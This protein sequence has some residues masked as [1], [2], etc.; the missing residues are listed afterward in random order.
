[1]SVPLT[2]G[3]IPYEKTVAMVMG[4]NSKSAFDGRASLVADIL[5][6]L[7]ELRISGMKVMMSEATGGY[8]ESCATMVRQE[9]VYY[10]NHLQSCMDVLARAAI[11][12]QTLVSDCMHAGEG[13]PVR[14]PLYLA[15]HWLLPEALD[16]M[17][18]AVD[19]PALLN[20]MQSC[21]IEELC[22][23]QHAF[24]FLVQRHVLTRQERQ[25]MR[26]VV[27]MARQHTLAFDL[28]SVCMLIK[29]GQHEVLDAILH[30][31]RNDAL[32]HREE[33]LAI[34]QVLQETLKERE[35]AASQSPSG[36][37]AI[38]DAKETVTLVRAVLM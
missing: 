6:R 26:E 24:I 15:M 17:L 16:I 22:G 12:E 20:T 7:M 30:T 2:Y 36:R 32:Q 34:T 31:Y 10:L 5:H 21:D 38:L 27:Q 18:S 29:M 14:T 4:M 25:A 13:K 19:D 33:L 28:I 8:R 9:T 23:P 35:R 11:L 37:L 1:V 3:D